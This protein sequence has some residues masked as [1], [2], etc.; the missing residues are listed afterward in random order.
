MQVDVLMFELRKRKYWT[1]T[2]VACLVV[3]LLVSYTMAGE[4]TPERDTLHYIYSSIVQGFAAFVGILFVALVF[5]QQRGKELIGDALDEAVES[6]SHLVGNI[7]GF[8]SK[9][10]MQTGVVFDALTK[11]K[12]FHDKRIVPPVDALSAHIND[13]RADGTPIYSAKDANDLV[14][15]H[16]E[17]IKNYRRAG[18]LVGRYVCE[19]KALRKF[20]M[21]I[22]T[23]AITMVA[24][25]L[26][27]LGGLLSLDEFSDVPRLRS[28]VA[29]F[30][31]WISAVMFTV[32]FFMLRNAFV[33]NVE[34][35]PDQWFK[36]T[37]LPDAE[38]QLKTLIE[39]GMR[40]MTSDTGSDKH[41]A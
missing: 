39:L 29:I 36:E 28:T 31:V 15:S 10:T 24:L 4:M 38:S 34:E 16:L 40:R 30:A 32:S 20:T 5:M 3:F 19:C 27:A 14:T 37:R 26:L 9:A 17:T 18:T 33:A 11:L 13:L 21:D 23:V 22:L 8:W 35:N 7:E 1:P 2:V 12:G 25:I 41:T 6:A